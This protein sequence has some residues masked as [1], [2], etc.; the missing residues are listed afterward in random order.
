MT[1]RFT[2]T[3]NRVLQYFVTLGPVGYFPY[4]P[5]TY[6]S[7]LSCILIYFFPSVCTHP[8]FV[9]AFA[10]ASVVALN[11]ITLEEKDPGY[12]VIDEVAGMFV[13]MAGHGVSLLHLLAGFLLFRFFDIVKPY[14]IRKMEMFRK[15]YG[16]VAD[17]ILAGIFANLLLVAGKR[18]L[19]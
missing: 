5:G 8:L 1:K 16:I 9:V 2:A 7:I 12:V 19:P 6:G 17:D 10:A 4:A 3:T 14:P 13:V 15:G 18:L 11:I